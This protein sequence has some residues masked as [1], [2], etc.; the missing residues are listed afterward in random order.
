MKDASGAFETAIAQGTTRLTQLL[1]LTRKDGVVHRRTTAQRDKT[2]DLELYK[3][4]GFDPTDLTTTTDQ[5]L[6]SIDLTC[7]FDD[8]ITEELVRLGALDDAKVRILWADWSLPSAGTIN[9][10]SGIVLNS[11][12]SN[13]RV[14]GLNIAGIMATA[15]RTIGETRSTTCRAIF[16][17]DRCKFD[18]ESMARNAVVIGQDNKRLILDFEGDPNPQ[19]AGE[20]DEW[21]VVLSMLGRS[22]RGEVGVAAL[23]LNG[24]AFHA[25]VLGSALVGTLFASENTVN[26]PNLEDGLDATVWRAEQERNIRIGIV[27]P[28]PSAV[29]EVYFKIP[30]IRNAPR[31]MK[32]Q[33]RDTGDPN[34]TDAIGFTRPKEG[35]VWLWNRGGHDA[36]IL[37]KHVRKVADDED[38]VDTNEEWDSFTDGLLK[39]T[40]GANLDDVYQIVKYQEN[41]AGHAIVDLVLRPAREIELGVDTV[42][43]Y[44]GC[45][46][47]FKRC[48]WWNNVINRRAEDY[49][50]SEEY[51]GQ[52]RLP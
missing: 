26:L 19:D 6:G 34:W 39:F 16:G 23:E 46:R 30:A 29:H 40:S 48:R 13:E 9:M 21:Q 31:Q 2:Y 36:D 32:L 22:A 4:G 8:E 17:D 14:C 7:Y 44:P 15:T 12:V 1:E 47:S 18:V 28:A 10:F 49:V 45:D 41:E 11:K 33:F 20:H 52:N 5:G 25:T 3:A 35:G 37:T 42:R 51:Q 38:D 43:I 24:L 27:L 50:P